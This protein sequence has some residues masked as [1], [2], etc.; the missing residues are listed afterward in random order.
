MK[1]MKYQAGEIEK[2]WQERWAEQNLYR[3][4]LK[5]SKKPKYYS[6]VMF[7]YP[8]G[9]KLHIGHWYNFA[10]ADSHARYMRMKGYNILEP[11]G[12][13]AFG[14]PAEN[15]AIK[16][17]V[18]P[19][20]SITKNVS[21][22][23]EQLKRMGCMYDWDKMV[24]TSEPNY[25]R[26]T[27]W[28]FLQMYKNGLAYQ[29]LAPV[30]WCPSC[31]T[32]L[33]N[34]QVQ[35]GTCERCDSVVTKKN[36]K[37]WFWKMSAYAQ[38]LL[39]GHEK[40]RGKWPENTILMQ[41]NWIGKSEGS[42]IAFGV[43]SLLRKANV[44]AVIEV[45]T[46][47]ADTLFGCTYVVLS[48]EHELTQKIVTREYR[49]K[50]EAYIE[51]TYE[52]S[53]VERTSTG[54]KTGVFTGAYALNPING[55]KVPVWVA[56]YVLASYGTGAV[57]A[58]P[59]HDERDFE[60]AKK[61]GLPIRHVV[62]PEKMHKR[63]GDEA[64]CFTE[65]GYLVN[66]DTLTGM[67]SAGARKA[68]IEFLKKLGRADFETTYRLRDWLVSRQRYWGAP[69]PIVYCAKCGEVPV[70]D[71]DLPVVLP[72]NVEFKPT[73][74]GKSPLASV[75]EFV[76]TKCPKCGGNAGRETDTMDTF[77]CSSFY[78]LRYL[79]QAGSLKNK[80]VDEKIVKK[81]MPVDMYIGGPEHACMHLIYARFVMMALKDFGYV[82]YDE[83]FARLVHQGLI[84]NKGAKMAKSKGNAVSPDEF[85]EKYGSDVFRMYLMFMGPFTE[86]GDWNERGITGI[87]RFADRFY[88]LITSDKERSDFVVESE[89]TLRLLH[90]TIKKVTQDIKVF[91]FNT[92]LALLME[93]VN[94]TLAHG[95]S[96]ET[97]KT[98][99]QL[100]APLAP[101][102]AEECF[103]HLGEK[104]SV[105]DS[106]W[107]EPN[108]KLLI[109]ETVKLII[110]VN[111]K[112][113]AAISVDPKISQE[114]AVSL[115]RQDPH[116][117][118]FLV[119]KKEGKV[120]FIAGRLLNLVVRD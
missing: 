93:F 73:G 79:D 84:T 45:F 101:H 8:S 29:K 17:G 89:E 106:T 86:G 22:M 60:F 75:P 47:R 42:L 74:D 39:D 52:K 4:D 38:R 36:L 59:A 103:S 97:K 72:K 105:F 108:Q 99:V 15:Y 19:T 57:M 64:I 77:V 10:P 119:G 9:D 14:L 11:M 56:D 46:T 110:Q 5:D 16:T 85:V 69:I 87:A 114:E 62:S 32:V 78:Y 30:N 71:M 115:A 107:P 80:F 37:Q 81:W 63:N 90:K 96:K 33:A 109:E 18:H 98:L 13:D 40:L 66:S 50:V 113:R 111:G 65:D 117:Q 49:R 6:L 112:F 58:V 68:I 100:I 76:K 51:L 28:V 26:W 102:L 118:K 91:H 41:K 92:A 27:Q 20:R 43:P 54:T 44:D 48:P 25:Y 1:A 2:K 31:K 61:Y 53:D 24:N 120:I 55:E 88:T 95:I 7:P 67:T 94:A 3:T 83:P 21:Y 104:N 70:K 116:V 82:P 23:I 35:E 12:F 34:E